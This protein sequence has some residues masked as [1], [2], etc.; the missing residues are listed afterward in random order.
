MPSRDFTCCEHG[1][2]CRPLPP[3]VEAAPRDLGFPESWK[4]RPPEL[5]SLHATGVALNQVLAGAIDAEKIE[6]GQSQAV[7]SRA[8]QIYRESTMSYKDAMRRARTETEPAG[9]LAQNTALIDPPLRT[10]R[11]ILF[12]HRALAAATALEIT[13]LMAELQPL[14]NTRDV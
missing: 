7:I 13:E 6:Q 1:T 8:R 4:A 3:D 11:E 9:H 14:F 12:N 5:R 10:L 2:N